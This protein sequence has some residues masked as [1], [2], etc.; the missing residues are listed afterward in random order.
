MKF[1]IKLR[2]TNETHID[3]IKESIKGELYEFSLMLADMG[4]NWVNGWD[5]DGERIYRK[6]KYDVDVHNSIITY[7][8]NKTY[9]DDTDIYDL[10][11]MLFTALHYL[12]KE[13]KIP[14]GD[15]TVIKI[16]DYKYVVESYGKQ[17]EG[18]IEV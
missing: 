11:D 2:T 18:I 14:E 8:F 7:I 16:E 4:D 15:I 1:K 17:F 13:N 5:E 9:Y 10:I 12:H 3:L 6:V